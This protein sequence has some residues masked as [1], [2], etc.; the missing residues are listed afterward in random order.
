MTV[1]QRG[2]LNPEMQRG[3][4]FRSRSHTWSL[5]LSHINKIAESVIHSVQE[6]IYRCLE[7]HAVSWT[8]T[9]DCT[10]RHHQAFQAPDFIFFLILTPKNSGRLIFQTTQSRPHIIPSETGGL[11]NQTTIVKEATTSPVLRPITAIHNAFRTTNP[12][13]LH[14]GEQ[15]QACRGTFQGNIN[16]FQ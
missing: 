15:E 10:T 2:M 9:T 13:E 6:R 8:D 16:S 7:V 14:H 4:Q 5:T 1:T 12:P 3:C 11:E